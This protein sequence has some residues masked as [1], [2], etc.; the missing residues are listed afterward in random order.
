[1]EGMEMEVE[2]VD[3]RSTFPLSG[4]CCL[5]GPWR[6]M[7]IAFTEK[8]FHAQTLNMLSLGIFDCSSGSR[9]K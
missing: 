4:H 5:L 2:L 9:N 1:M 6:S 8:R 7:Q 3:T